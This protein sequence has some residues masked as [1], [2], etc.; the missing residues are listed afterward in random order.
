MK[1]RCTPAHS[2]GNMVAIFCKAQNKL[3][4]KNYCTAC[5]HIMGQIVMSYTTATRI[6]Y[7]NAFK[8]T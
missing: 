4:E 7:F 5:M 3:E 6:K 2:L 1:T 8:E